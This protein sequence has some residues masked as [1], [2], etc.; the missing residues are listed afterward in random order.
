MNHYL[1]IVEGAHDVALVSSILR[2][3]KFKCIK[4]YNQINHPFNKLIIDKF[5]YDKSNLDIYN[6]LPPFY[7]KEDKNICI[8]SADGEMKLIKSLDNAVSKFRI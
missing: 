4:N 6:K 7:I 1:F 5:P 3:L 8:I 2:V